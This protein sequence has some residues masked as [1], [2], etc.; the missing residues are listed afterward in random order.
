MHVPTALGARR[1][2]GS[3]TRAKAERDVW[4]KYSS[5]MH[6]QQSIQGKNNN[7]AVTLAPGQRSTVVFSSTASGQI[8]LPGDNT[9][10]PVS[11]DLS[12][13]VGM[14]SVTESLPLS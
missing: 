6:R 1:R 3:E 4:R 7:R 9:H 5:A 13:T 2:R 10:T 8:C 11:H 12:A 14:G